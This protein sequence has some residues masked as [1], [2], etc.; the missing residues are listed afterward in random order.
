MSVILA[1]GMVFGLIPNL[2]ASETFAAST[3]TISKTAEVLDRGIKG[4]G[5]AASPIKVKVGEKI[6]YTITV[7][8]NTPLPPRPRYDVLFVL[9]W[10]ASMNAAYGRKQT[11]EEIAGGY[12]ASAR[13]LAKQTIESLSRRIFDEYPDSR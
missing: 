11:P 9:D 5:S 7:D 4:A 2:K 13:V 1:L 12:T 10:S 8:T 3:P 6:K